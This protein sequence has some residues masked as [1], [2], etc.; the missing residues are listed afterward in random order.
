MEKIKK[1]FVLSSIIAMLVVA[2]SSLYFANIYG[3]SIRPDSYRSFL[4][5]GEGKVTAVSDIAQFSFSV[6]TQGGKDIAAIQK[7]NS[8]KT[9]RAIGVAK[10]SGVEDKDIKTIVYDL[11]PRYQTFSCPNGFNAFTSKPCPPSE[12]V[13]YTVT[14]TVS[15]KVRNFDKISEI[16]AGVV[17]SGANSVSQLT[18]TIDNRT[19]LENRARQE[20]IAQAIKKAELIAEAGGFKL[21]R[22]LSINEG[23]IFEPRFESVA[24][25]GKG[26]AAADAEPPVIEPGSQEIQ[27]NV[28][29]VYEIR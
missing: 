28:T 11:E 7:E 10:A 6:I 24:A 23:G 19:D 15:V 17:Q 2:A 29:V 8:E 21:G 20:A 1:Y 16:L 22:L 27:V 13:G 9:N 14:Q 18:F 3:K 4:A 26:G 5:S 25:F 12:I